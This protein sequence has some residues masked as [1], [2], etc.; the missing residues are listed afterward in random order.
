MPSIKEQGG[1]DPWP[2]PA[3]GQLEPRKGVK[4]VGVSSYQRK[5]APVEEP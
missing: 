4:S 3:P 1:I 5:D 2:K